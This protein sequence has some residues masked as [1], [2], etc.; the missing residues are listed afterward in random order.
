MSPPKR[1]VCDPLV[2][3]AFAEYLV[4]PVVVDVR[5][6]LAARVA[7][8]RE[9]GDVEVRPPAIQPA[10]AIGAGNPQKI[11]AE[12]FVHA[13]R[14]RQDLDQRDPRIT[15][16]HEIRRQRVV[17]AAGD[18]VCVAESFA[19]LGRGRVHRLSTEV[20]E[21]RRTVEVVV[22]PSEPARE[23]QL[24]RRVE[25]DLRIGLATAELE[26]S[27]G[28]IVVAE[29]IRERRQRQGRDQLQND[30]IQPVRRDDVAG[31]RRAA[32]AI[33]G[34]GQ[35]VVDGIG[36]RGKITVA[37]GCRRHRAESLRLLPVVGPFVAGEEEQ[38]VPDERTA[39]RPA[40]LV[41]TRLGFGLGGRQ[42]VR[43]RLQVLVEVIAERRAAQLIGSALDHH[44]RRHAAGESLIGV[45]RAGDDADGVDGLQRRHVR[46]DVRQPEVVRNG[47]FDPDG[48]GVARR[49]VRIE[50]Q[51]AR[52][53]HRH[54]VH[55]LRRGDAGNRDE[56][57]LVVAAERNRQVLQLRR[58]DLGTYVGAIGLQDRC[59]GA[60][61]HR[62][63]E[64]PERQSGG[65]AGDVVLR[66]A[67]VGRDGLVETR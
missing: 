18:R 66:H 33:R 42:E 44:V 50:A 1:R 27:S 19:G 65:H 7:D 52:G 36:R 6:V 2:Q 32:A 22:Q 54:R 31:K 67:D 10:G 45:E 60:H 30:R 46:R 13:E 53:V 4:L 11:Q 12:V 20:A 51:A 63:R 26:E 15:L 28:E 21:H 59:A 48:V 39:H 14:F 29:A 17:R 37:H 16:D 40:E 25:S 9:A 47:P 23:H 34:A 62:I 49:S 55:V 56:Q 57:V 5:R 38:L 35:R 8:A 41:L 64:L 61:R 43:P 24:A 58:S 3:L